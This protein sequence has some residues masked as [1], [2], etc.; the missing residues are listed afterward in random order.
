MDDKQM[1]DREPEQM[2]LGVFYG[3]SYL[4]RILQK[5]NITSVKCLYI[6]NHPTNNLTLHI[7]E[8][9]ETHSSILPGEPPWTE[10]PGQLQ[11]MGLQRAGHDRA[12]EYGMKQAKANRV[13]PRERTGNSKHSLPTTQEKTLHVDITRWSTPKSD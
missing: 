4:K 3:S 13:L 10:E 1:I 7:H 11:S 12:L 6:A 5:P 9:M 2:S 8:G